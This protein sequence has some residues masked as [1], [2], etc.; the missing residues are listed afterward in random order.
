MYEIKKTKKGYDIKLTRGDYFATYIGI[1]D[2]DE[3]YQPVEGDKLRF[4]IKH[5]ILK[6]DGSD[7]TDASPLVNINIPLDT[8]LLQVQSAD[9]KSLAFGEYAYDIELTHADGKPDTFIKG[10]LELTEEVY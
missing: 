7:Y 3:P 8:C 9:T 10:I 5:N 6:S 2:I 4:A 1:T